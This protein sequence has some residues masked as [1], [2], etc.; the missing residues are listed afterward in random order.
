MN[1]G[2][3]SLSLFDSGARHPDRTAVRPPVGQRRGGRGMR[4]LSRTSLLLLVGR[5]GTGV[6]FLCMVHSNRR[7]RPGDGGAGGR[8]A[9]VPALFWTVRHGLAWRC[10][11]PPSI[12]PLH[13]GS[14]FP[15]PVLYLNL[16]PSNPRPRWARR[17]WIPASIQHTHVCWILLAH[18]SHHVQPIVHPS[19]K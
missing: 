10:V 12:R 17:L 9:N 8:D 7:G 14:R 2:R 5:G 16:V 1:L 15:H 13:G 11:S 18:F 6:R 4:D 19:R 3:R